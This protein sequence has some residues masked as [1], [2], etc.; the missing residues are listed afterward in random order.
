MFWG[1][2]AGGGI[3]GALDDTDRERSSWALEA[4]DETC[5]AAGFDLLDEVCASPS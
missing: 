4:D 1:D 3:A 2:G 5:D